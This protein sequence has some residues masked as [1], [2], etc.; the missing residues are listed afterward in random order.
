MFNPPHLRAVA[1]TEF[2]M[3]HGEGDL[4]LHTLP[5]GPALHPA[6]AGMGFCSVRLPSGLETYSVAFGSRDTISVEGGEGVESLVAQQHWPPKIGADLYEASTSRS[7]R[8]W[9]RN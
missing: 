6:M 1:N 2:S 7:V 9:Y 8:V 3:R 4:S 5:A